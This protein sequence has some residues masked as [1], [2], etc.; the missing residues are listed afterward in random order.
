MQALEVD[1]LSDAILEVGQQ[2]ASVVE[3]SV[4]GS[5]LTCE[6]SAVAAAERL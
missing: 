4:V 2:A 1:D 3:K 6:A 5:V